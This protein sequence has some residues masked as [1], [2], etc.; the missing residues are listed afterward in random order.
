MKRLFLALALC[1]AVAGAAAKPLFLGGGNPRWRRRRLAI[2]LRQRQQRM[3]AVPGRADLRHMD[4]R[5]DRG[6]GRGFPLPPL[7]ID[8]ADRFQATTPARH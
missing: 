4:R 7:P 1:I 6:L 5:G 3:R 2:G 8:L